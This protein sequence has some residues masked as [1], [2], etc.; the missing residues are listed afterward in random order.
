ML[1]SGMLDELNGVV[2]CGK[3]AHVYHCV[4]GDFKYGSPF[5]GVQILV[6]TAGRD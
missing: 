4:G 5:A 2:S 3:E 6:V 1:N